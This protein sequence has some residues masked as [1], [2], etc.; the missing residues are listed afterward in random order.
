MKGKGETGIE[1]KSR[2]VDLKGEH[3]CTDTETLETLF[4]C[5]TSLQKYYRRRDAKVGESMGYLPW[6]CWVFRLDLSWGLFT[7][8][9]QHFRHTQVLCSCLGRNFS[10]MHFLPVPFEESSSSDIAAVEI[11]LLAEKTNTD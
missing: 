1:K 10:F 8:C 9:A 3:V 7:L 5:S 2:M 6:K 4:E 11:S